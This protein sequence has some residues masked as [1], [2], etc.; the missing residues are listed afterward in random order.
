M[1]ISNN[2][3]E[4]NR[5]FNNNYSLQ[6][7]YIYEI[8]IQNLEKAQ[9]LENNE[10]LA[11][12]YLTVGNFWNL[13]GNKVKA[14]ENY[15]K[16]ETIS[17]KYG[18]YKL[19]GASAAN[20]ANLSEDFNTRLNGL[21]SAINAYVKGKDNLNYAR[22]CALIGD[23]YSVQ[24]FS[25]KYKT[26]SKIKPITF[27]KQQAYSFYKKADS[28]NQ[29]LKSDEIK[30]TIIIN[31]AEWYKYE[32][33]YEKAIQ[34]FKEAETYLLKSGTLKGVLYSKTEIASIYI[35]QKKF[36]E[37]IKVLDEA[38][39]MATD[40]NI[41]DYLVDIYKKYIIY[42]ETTGNFEKAL[43]YQRKYSDSLVVLNNASSEDKLHIVLLEH[44]LQENEFKVETQRK[45][46]LGLIVG[47]SIIVLLG[48]GLIYF[49]IRNRKRKIDSLKKKRI[50]VQLEKE[51]LEVKLKNQQLEEQLIKE[52][53]QFSQ[54]NLISFA[55]QINKIEFFLDELKS[56]V[57]TVNKNGID[58]AQ[59]NNL[60]IAF[61]ELLHNKTD[62]QQINT[63]SNKQHI[64]FFF[65][66]SKKFP[67]I[68]KEDEQLLQLILNGKTT[69]EISEI[70]SISTNSLFTKRYR[71]RKKLNL[72][73]DNSFEDLYDQFLKETK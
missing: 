47:I 58:Q 59:I 22:I 31:Y 20:K 44:N 27:Y 32:K 45:I 52:K 34:T 61:Q 73:K 24:V 70:Y 35:E 3:I 13:K 15:L 4:I 63:L 30:G 12:T 48:S 11:D 6:P 7:E 38:N 51:S 42:F 49:I 72:E 67:D 71:L 66:L 36:S 53:M 23:T 43:E 50:I 40:Y 64:D 54:N 1:Q 25:E 57:R 68:T 69:R 60:K 37:A 2:I 56:K 65:Y 26:N 41:S 18:Y 9:E 62:L 14:F 16:S 55:N 28:I 10:A 33:N 5:I 19:L 29:T 8:L 46:N 21:T 39:Q 17:K